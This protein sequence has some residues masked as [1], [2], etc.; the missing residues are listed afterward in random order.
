MVDDTLTID[1]Q[2]AAVHGTGVTGGAFRLTLETEPTESGR[3]GE[4]ST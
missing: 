1:G 2:R 3:H 4:C